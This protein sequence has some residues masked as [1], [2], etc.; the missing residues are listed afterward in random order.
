MEN[1]NMILN[2]IPSPTWNWLHMNET[3]V[4]NVAVGSQGRI[5]SDIPGGVSV[6]EENK[7]GLND[8]TALGED[9]DR[10]IVSSGCKVLSI[11]REK[12][13][14]DSGEPVRL[15]FNYEA[16]KA[17]ANAV[18]IY[19][20]EGAELTVIMNFE[21]TRDAAA[22]AAV[23]TRYHVAKDARL[24]LVQ[25]EKLGDKFTF[26]ND[27]GGEVDELGSFTLTQLVL[28]GKNTYQGAYNNLTGKKA[29]LQTEI[30]YMV[31]SDQVL[32][33]NYVA[34]HT[35]K[36]TKCV[37]NADG[38]LRGNAKKV[39]RGTI[40]FRRGCAGAKGDE[41]ENVL[42]MD[43]DV[44]NQTIPVILCDEEDVAGEHGST[45]GKLSN[46]VLFYMN[47]HGISQ[48]EAEKIMTMSKINRVSSLIPDEK[49]KTRIAEYIEEAFNE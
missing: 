9:M 38:V 40:D 37:M 34:Y 42:L 13:A 25:V 29:S 32:D 27:I 33:M 14:S 23:Q 45:I 35:G 2:Q 4:D 8:K 46:D 21:S 44:I 28:S 41:L 10:L 43:D 7:A 36:K 39:F 22:T 24:T 47:A 6:K 19:V 16:D 1:M 11:R 12:E 18:E 15:T 49:L 26:L 31:L 30:G 48:T 3:Q 5:L 17:A 20:E